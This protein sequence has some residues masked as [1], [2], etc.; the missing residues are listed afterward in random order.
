MTPRSML[1]VGQAP[2]A[3][4]GSK[5]MQKLSSKFQA[6]PKAL[7]PYPTANMQAHQNMFVN[8]SKKTKEMMA[9]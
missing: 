5:M 6:A 1:A 3:L 2:N 8:M 9:L 4:A 7:A